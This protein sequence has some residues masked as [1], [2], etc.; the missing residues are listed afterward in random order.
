MQ[1]HSEYK[2]HVGGSLPEDARS[3]V[4]RD[5]DQTFYEGLRAGEF[6]YV[7]NSRQMG[8]SSLRVRAMTRLQA[9]GI[10][11]A[12][13]DLSEIGSMETTAT[14]LYAG[15]ISF[16][17]N[18]LCLPDFDLNEWWQSEG[19][20]SPVQ[21]LSKFFEDVLLKKVQG[22]VVIFID[23]T[24]AISRFGEDFFAL[25]RSFY[26]KRSDKPDFNRL[27]FGILGVAS[28]GDLIKDKKKTPFNIGIGIRMSG[29]QLHEAMPLA[30]GLEG[31]AEDPKAVLQAILDW[32]GGQPFL[33]QKVCDRLNAELRTVISRGEEAEA[34]GQLVRERMTDNWESKDEPPHLKPIRDRVLHEGGQRTCRLL[35]LYAMVLADEVIPEDDT[36]E[37]MELRLSGLV[38]IRE[39]RL[40]V[41]NRIY[42]QV[43]DQEWTEQALEDL[44]PYS[45]NFNA[46]KASEC[47][48]ESRLL[49]GE[50]LD[51]AL[52]WSEDKSLSDDEHRFLRVSEKLDA[53]LKSAELIRQQKDLALAAINTLTYGLI[54][55]L[56]EIPRTT[57]IV[58]RILESNTEL[59]EKI[60]AL[61]PDT[62]KARREKGANL[63]R[64]GDSWLLL[65]ETEQALK[66]YQECN[67]IL[68]KL[69]GEDPENTEAQRD[70]S[71][72]YNKL[73]DVLMRQGS[74]AEALKA[75]EQAME[76]SRKLA[77]GDPENS[78]AQRDLSVSYGKLGKIYEALKNP[79]AALKEYQKSFPIDQELAKDKL[80]QQARDDLKFTLNKLCSLASQLKQYDK[81]VEYTQLRIDHSPEPDAGAFGTLSWYLLFAGKPEQ[82]IQAAEKGLSIDPEQ[83]WINTNLIPGH[84]LSGNMG[85]AKQIFRQHADKKLKEESFGQVLLNDLKTFEEA[86]I[87]HPDIEVFKAFMDN[88]LR[89][90]DKKGK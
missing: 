30:K 56:L 37:Q 71:V 27:T 73:G 10:A 90:T 20:L 15:M 48:D 3:Y 70:L 28:P 50:A 51:E 81:A 36:P 62:R 21:Y 32:T 26:E 45:A 1:D 61:D 82:A 23:E 67:E 52:E 57:K 5:A 85:K 13:I 60:H 2:Y 66:A 22:Q 77:A 11:C 76:I 64:L 44:R 59:L 19:L 54:D 55:E 38:V 12:V 7:L 86:G 6:C 35:G 8:K 46:W 24:D 63:Q 43:F 9:E 49:R 29:F 31:R 40:R 47:Q 68:E 83:I 14:K 65:G 17:V 79:E 58:T 88:Y 41:Y 87:R 84:L 25:V 16:I 53:A 33:T 89:K 39:N 78:S 69:A 75:F 34:V 80:S 74:T 4:T 18:A 72:S 42:A